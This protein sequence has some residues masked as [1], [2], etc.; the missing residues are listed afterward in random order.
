M[1]MADNA[2][3]EQITRE[4][5]NANTMPD[6][7]ASVRSRPAVDWTGDPIIRISIVVRPETEAALTGQTPLNILTKISDQLMAVGE[8]R[9][10]I[11]DYATTADR[12]PADDDPES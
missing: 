12:E 4:I 10:P 3:I 8:D 2:E 5:V 6:A 9:F 1:I 7:V 11:I